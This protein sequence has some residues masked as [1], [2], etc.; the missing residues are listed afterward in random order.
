MIS[1]NRF[2]ELFHEVFCYPNY[3]TSYGFLPSYSTDIE[4]FAPLNFDNKFHLN[5]DVNGQIF[6]WCE[7]PLN[8][9]DFENLHYYPLGTNILPSDVSLEYNKGTNSLIPPIRSLNSKINISIIANSEKSKMK[10]SLL[11]K[12]NYQDWYFF[13]HGFAALDWFR[14]FRFFQKSDIKITKLFICLNHLIDKKRSYRLNLLNQLFQNDFDKKG[15]ISASK[16]N[17]ELVK[18]EI[19][20]SYSLLSLQTKKDIFKN[21]YN[22]AHPIFLDDKQNFSSSSA[23]IIDNTFSLSAL[24]H[25]VPE[26]IFYDEKLHLTEKIFKPIVL[27]RPFVL[28]G[29]PGNLAYLKEYGFKTFDRWINEDYDDEPDPDI[30]IK[31]AVDEIKKLQGKNLQDMYNEMLPILEYNH[32]HFYTKFKEIIVEEAID[33]FKKAVFMYNKDLSFRFQ[34]PEVLD[35]NHIKK[36]LLT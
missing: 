9:Q 1:Y 2:Y 16:L 20:D 12:Y 4:N 34:L 26:T 25:I 13:F 21:L 7:E 22:R 10:N 27:R 29:A 24:W 6:W 31:K 23:D 3:L 18:K 32:N 17:Q 19:F 14:D 11:Q 8:I 5:D 15:Y 36:L 33:N 28:I 35:Y 30:R